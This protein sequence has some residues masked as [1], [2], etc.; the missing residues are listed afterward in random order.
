MVAAKEDK[1][2][3]CAGVT[4]ACGD[5]DINNVTVAEAYRG[6]GIGRLMLSALIKW[7]REIGIENYT[8]EVRV[9]NAPAV[10][11]YESLGFTSA[12][13]RP[14]FYERPVEDAMIMWLYLPHL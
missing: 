5:G 7:G 8:L 14:R 9:S 11:L 6:Q 10:R 4:N 13:I 3:G 12:G 1:I 2:I